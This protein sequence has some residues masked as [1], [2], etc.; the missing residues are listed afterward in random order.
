MR[1]L[2]VIY[3]EWIWGPLTGNLPEI[4]LRGFFYQGTTFRKNQ[5]EVSQKV[6][7][8]LRV[9]TV[10]MSVRCY[11]DV[12]WC[13]RTVLLWCYCDVTVVFSDVSVPSEDVHPHLGRITMRNEDFFRWE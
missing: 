11:C 7:S 5:P 1:S 9:L 3:S 4:R 8:I 10:L 12:Q 2:F 13:V 6:V